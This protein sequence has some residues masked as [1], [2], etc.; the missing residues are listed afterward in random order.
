MSKVISSD[1][2]KHFCNYC[3]K[4]RNSIG[5][6]SFANYI[7]LAFEQHYVLSADSPDAFQSIAMRDR[8]SNYDWVRSGEPVKDA[9]ANA[10]DIVYEIAEDVQSIL[11]Q[12]HY[13]FDEYE[14]PFADDSYYEESQINHYI[15]NEIWRDLENSIISKNRHFNTEVA[16]ILDSL[17]GDIDSKN[18]A[19]VSVGLGT[20]IKSFYRARSFYDRDAIKKAL[21]SPEKELG[22]PPPGV[23]GAG[24]MNAQ[25]VS[26]FYGSDMPETAIAEVRP[27]VGSTVV[28]ARF[29]LTTTLNLLDLDALADQYKV[30]SIFDPNSQTEMERNAFLRG[31]ERKLIIPSSP[32]KEKMDYVV[33]QTIA[34]YLDAHKAGI[35]GIRFRST[36]VA[37]QSF[38]VVLFNKSSKVTPALHGRALNV[39]GM[40]DDH[41]DPNSDYKYHAVTEKEGEPWDNDKLA[42]KL[43]CHQSNDH[44]EPALEIDILSIVINRIEGVGYN[45]NSYPLTR[46]P[47]NL[48]DFGI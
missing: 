17:F 13:D 47:I 40:E 4:T 38:N 14:S 27:T 16:E 37:K 19:L 9:I 48:T 11:Q 22:S 34:D 20:D 42:N 32:D 18:K 21:V 6:E 2:K 33:T 5:L 7:E 45:L 24:R 36:Q 35:D 29:N 26:V 10:A 25:G 30:H 28:T 43:N 12:R 1:G 44:R 46:D 23:N 39:Y 41:D 3:K 15:W 8:E 31:L